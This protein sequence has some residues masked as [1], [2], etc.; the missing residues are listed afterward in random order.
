MRLDANGC[1]AIP[2]EHT[3]FRIT[4]PL[5]VSQTESEKAEDTPS[6]NKELVFELHGSQF[7]TRPV[8]RANKKFKWRNVDYL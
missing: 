3:V 7:E 8:D 6:T 1:I 2:K 5:S 4:V